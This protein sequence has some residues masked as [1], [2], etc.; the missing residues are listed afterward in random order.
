VADPDGFLPPEENS[1]IFCC[2]I[3]LSA[4]IHSLVSSQR[5]HPAASRAP[6][7]LPGNRA[8]KT[9]F[10]AAQQ[11]D[12]A[13]MGITSV[14]I[15]DI[16]GATPQLI[17]ARVESRVGLESCSVFAEGCRPRRCT[18]SG[19]LGHGPGG[20]SPFFAQCR[21]AAAREIYFPAVSTGTACI[22]S[23]LARV[24]RSDLVSGS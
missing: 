11:C 20:S 4:E 10:I 21:T 6:P 18:G 19:E 7:R 5:I 1:Y 15:S 14:A 23:A 16:H 22:W 17:A 3:P 12:R 13:L 24:S 2:E 9:L 8:V